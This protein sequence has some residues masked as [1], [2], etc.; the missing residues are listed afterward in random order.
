MKT[1]KMLFKLGLFAMVV[2]CFCM[3]STLAMTSFKLNIEK[4]N[5]LNKEYIS[6]NIIP[7]HFADNWNDFGWF[8]YFSNGV[9]IDESTGW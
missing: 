7:I 2:W 9:W 5:A 4:I 1:K 8:F 6:N 3:S